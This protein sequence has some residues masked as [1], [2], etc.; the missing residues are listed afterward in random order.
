MGFLK[1]MRDMQSQGQ[2]MAQQAQAGAGGMGMGDQVAY[3][4]MAQKLYH[5]GVEASGVVNAIRPSG[6]TDISGAQWVDFDV[7]INKPDGTQY[8]TTIKQSIVGGQLDDIKEGAT[9]TVKYDPDQPEVALI[10]GW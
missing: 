5:G 9:V 7:T 1:N 2:A 8:Q 10:H 6:Q 3:G 4:Q